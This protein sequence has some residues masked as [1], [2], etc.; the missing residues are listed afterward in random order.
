MTTRTAAQRRSDARI[1]HQDR[2]AACSTNR[3]LERLGEKWV[4]LI[5]KEL[6]EGPRR[7]GELAQS[8]A[9]ASQKMLT[10]T[11]RRLERDGLLSRTLTPSVP[12]RVD[13]ALTPLGRS[14]LPVLREVTR[15]AEQN[16]AAIDSA[17]TGYDDQR[18][19]ASHDDEQRGT[20]PHGRR[21]QG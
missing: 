1:A 15:W 19:R 21:G 4:A 18:S 13:Y 2:F 11:L 14:L 9:G 7:Y 17:R 6:T 10:E 12:V 5:L 3:L 16:M 8:I 20:G